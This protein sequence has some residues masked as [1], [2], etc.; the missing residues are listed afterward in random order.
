[1]NHQKLIT[2][3]TAALMAALT[4][5]GTLIIHIPSPTGYIHPGDAFVILSGIFLGPFYGGLAAGI[6]SMLADL[7]SGYANY[8]L[9]TFLIKALAAIVA[10][11]AYRHIRFLSIIIAST[12]AGVIVT[13]G[14]FLFDSFI[15]GSGLASAIKGIPFN[16]V[17]NLSGIIIATILLPL[18]LL[19]PQV[20]SMVQNQQ[21][22]I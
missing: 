18:L 1:M 20:K 12:L 8:A 16:L 19:V 2:L 3:V 15:S 6:G 13:S 21:H 10:Y 14:Y 11:Y 22:H 4:C 17:Q 9:A 5:V 7:L